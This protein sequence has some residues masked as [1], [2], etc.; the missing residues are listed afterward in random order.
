MSCSTAYTFRLSALL[1][2]K[3]SDRLGKFNFI[4]SEVRRWDALF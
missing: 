1:F 2:G 4:N 3:F